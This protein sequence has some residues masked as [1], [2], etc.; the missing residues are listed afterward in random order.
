MS[1]KYL[2]PFAKVPAPKLTELERRLA[3][4]YQ[5]PP[6]SYYQIANQ[7]ASQYTRAP[8]PFHCH[9]A[10]QSF[11]GAQILELGCGTAHFC[12]HIEA[13]GGIYHGVDYSLDLIEKNRQTHPKATFW[14]MGTQ[15]RAMFDL[16]VSLYTIEHVPNPPRYL[17]Q[18]WDYCRP[19]GIIGIICPDFVDGEGI[20]PS[21]YYG[22]SPVR[23]RSKL[24]RG[25]ILDALAHIIDL[26]IIGPNWKKRSRSMRPGSFW[27]N[28][29]PSDLAGQKHRIDGDAVHFPRMIDI[30]DWLKRQSAT[31]IET[32]RTLHD[33]LKDVLKHNCYVLAKKTR[34]QHL[35]IVAFNINLHYRASTR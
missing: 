25:R 33:I 4:F 26:K 8:Q 11:P 27:I 34:W 6:P 17:K 3:A 31:I 20:P 22:L 28:L 30:E 12:P 9:L 24:A 16:V 18:L 13:N 35:P 15:P 5:N 10:A 21:V 2:I 23:I 29:D 14:Q 32:S 7:A 1:F 19:G